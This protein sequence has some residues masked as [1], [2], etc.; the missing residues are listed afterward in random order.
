MSPRRTNVA[1]T[2]GVLAVGAAVAVVAFI[3]WL[4]R[5]PGGEFRLGPDTFTAGRA[6]SLARRIDTE[7]PVGFKDPLGRGRNIWVTHLGGRR[8]AAFEDRLPGG[9]RLVLRRG[10]TRLRNSCTGEVQPADPR[11]PRHYRVS[12]DDKGRVV[13]DLRR[14]L[15]A[16]H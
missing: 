13:V 1:L 2:A 7:G 9:C 16:A 11:G 8:F 15:S 6:D 3:L 12:V 4:A 14:P 10:E 5:Q